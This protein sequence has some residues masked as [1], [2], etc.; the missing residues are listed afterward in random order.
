[1]GLNEIR[2]GNDGWTLLSGL[3]KF[4]LRRIQAEIISLERVPE[5]QLAVGTIVGQASSP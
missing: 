5:S 2:G 1:M 3:V 4:I